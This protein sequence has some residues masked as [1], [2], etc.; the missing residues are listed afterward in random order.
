MSSLRKYISFYSI[1]KKNIIG[2]ITLVPGPVSKLRSADLLPYELTLLWDP[3]L[4][5]NGEVTGYIVTYTGTK[6]NAEPHNLEEPVELGATTY[7]YSAENLTAG[8]TYE[9]EV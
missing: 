8:Y 2:L 4:A 7:R 1:A 3:P 5:P 6:D 9:F